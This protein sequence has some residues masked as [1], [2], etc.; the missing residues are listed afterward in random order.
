V[1]QQQLEVGEAVRG[2][3]L[4]ARRERTQRIRDRKVARPIWT[5]RVHSPVA[6]RAIITVHEVEHRD[7]VARA[8]PPEAIEACVAR[9]SEAKAERRSRKKPGRGDRIEEDCVCAYVCVRN[10][11]CTEYLGTS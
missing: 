11:K 9:G 2:H 5:R 1:L 4:R 10:G 7:Q 6:R 8:I 3:D